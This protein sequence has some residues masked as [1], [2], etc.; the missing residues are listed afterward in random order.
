M[1][2]GSAD[3]DVV[4]GSE[5]QGVALG[6]ANQDMEDVSLYTCFKCYKRFSGL[7]QLFTHHRYIHNLHLNTSMKIVS[8][9]CHSTYSVYRPY[10]RH[11]QSHMTHDPKPLATEATEP[12]MLETK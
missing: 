9:L 12:V 3:Q 2:P 6:P 4:S 7:A 8:L 10:K 5:D 11:M 1:A